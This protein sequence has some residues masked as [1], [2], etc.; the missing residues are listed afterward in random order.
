MYTEI[1]NV[2]KY[3]TTKPVTISTKFLEKD[4]RLLHTSYKIMVVIDGEATIKINEK[5]YALTRDVF[6]NISPWTIMEI[7][8]I[9]KPVKYIILS[10]NRLYISRIINTINSKELKLFKRLDDFEYIHLT[11]KEV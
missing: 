11:K 2:S 3:N 10:Y 1:E 7:N 6:I 5:E 8:N 9:K 4:T